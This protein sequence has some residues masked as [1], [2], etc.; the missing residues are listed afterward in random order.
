[1]SRATRYLTAL[2]CGALTLAS[3]ACAR[4]VQDLP[5]PAPGV[6]GPGYHLEAV[7]TNALNLPDR[8]K[9]RVGGADVG[10]VESMRVR[11]YTAV[12][13]LRVLDSV[14]LP[15]GT[16]A[17]LRSATPLGDVFVALRPPATAGP[18]LR[19][20]D[21]IAVGSTVAAATVEEVLASTSLLVNGGV[22]GN[23]T[24]VLNGVGAATDDGGARLTALVTQ[25][26]ELLAT[27]ALRT[28]ELRG[29]LAQ[30]ASL[31]ED[32]NARR[33]AIDDILVT[34]GPALTVIADNTAQIAGLA[35]Q[36]AALTTRLRRLPSI[37]GT[38]T[39]S[40]VHDLNELSRAFNVAAT[41]P[42]VTMANLLRMLPPTLKFFSA[43]AAHSDVDLHQVVVGPVD[44][45]GHLADPQF[46]APL[47]E[48]WAN[49]VGS[50]TFVLTQL[51]NRVTG[52][53]R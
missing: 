26:R 36:V 28:D 2:L 22:I 5:L 53:G 6:S 17:E 7:F 41:D 3:A 52:G 16:T 33:G 50:L 48:D 30:T 9:V 35:D 25:S 24:R 18:T 51:G 46:R 13:R 42:R 20:G 29:V 12:V 37:A 14:R 8:A 11:D 44:D 38:D 34:A 39:R 40:L 47:P 43:N 1:M 21:T 45:P 10:E 32:L 31:A 27:M 4:G 23:L 15:V 19:D 49:L